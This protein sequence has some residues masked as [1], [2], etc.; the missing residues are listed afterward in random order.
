M[1]A[2]KSIS[3]IFLALVLLLSSFLLFACGKE[4]SSKGAYKAYNTFMTQIKQDT[5][6]FTS[7]QI[8]NLYTDFYLNDFYSKDNA[9]AKV[10]QN[11][12]YIALCA[13][14][15]EFI[16]EYYPTLET[17]K[18]K[19]DYTSLKDDVKS[20]T[21]SYKNLKAEHENLKNNAQNLDTTIY[22]GYF[23]RYRTYA[24]KFINK[25]YSSALKL[26]KFL[27]NEAKLAKT[28][29]TDKVTDQAVE[30][31]CDYNILKVFDD[32]RNFFMNSC[33]GAY[34]DNDVYDNVLSMLKL[35]TNGGLVNKDFSANA[36]ESKELKNI[37]TQVNN[38]RSIINKAVSKF[39]VYKFA[40]TYDDSI[41]GY[42]KANENAP[43]YLN[44]INMYFADTGSTL[45]LTRV[46]LLSI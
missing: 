1:K 12:N 2:K 35:Y 45:N 7:K 38:E 16:D 6:L 9:G 28:I 17:L 42:E 43:A 44:K 36:N 25:S 24:G 31:Y 19:T 30:F 32:F 5:S 23:S 20:L 37:L 15:L 8:E 22:N 18:L 21:K 34:V 29:G 41:E 46:Y 11:N 14:S 40:N 27:N 33:K 10:Y 4:E 13:V 26:A 39:S 3:I